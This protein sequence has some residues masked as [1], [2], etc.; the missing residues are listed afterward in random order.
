MPTITPNPQKKKVSPIRPQLV[1]PICLLLLLSPIC[2]VA[3]MSDGVCRQYVPVPS[4]PAAVHGA[5]GNKNCLEAQKGERE[6]LPI[7][8]NRHHISTRLGWG[9]RDGLETAWQKKSPSPPFKQS[10][11]SSI[12]SP[13]RSCH[14]LTPFLFPLFCS[15]SAACRKFNPHTE[16]T[17]DANPTLFWNGI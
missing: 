4:C 13:P 2:L 5:A 12:S 14:W 17:N 6:D 16:R 10:P 1:S 8:H 9:E 3:N 7:L 15:D 11:L